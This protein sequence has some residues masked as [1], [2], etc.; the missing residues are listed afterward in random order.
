MKE[1][2]PTAQRGDALHNCLLQIISY[3][4]F[5]FFPNPWIYR[6][7]VHTAIARDNPYFS[8]WGLQKYR[9]GMHIPDVFTVLRL[10][11][12]YVSACHTLQTNSRRSPCNSEQYAYNIDAI[13]FG[14]WHCVQFSTKKKCHE[15]Y[16]LNLIR[17]IINLI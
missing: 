13:L 4:F 7:M 16:I 2:Q 5:P 14:V 12:F 8:I 9:S 17:D 11:V 3:F 15:W 10:I 6:W 1:G